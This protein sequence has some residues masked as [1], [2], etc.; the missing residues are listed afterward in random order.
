VEA[1]VRRAV[2]ETGTMDKLAPIKLRLPDSVD[3]GEIR[4]VVAAI[5][6][7]QKSATKR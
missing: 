5:R 2:H 1:Q 7:E 4:C 3:Y 6:A